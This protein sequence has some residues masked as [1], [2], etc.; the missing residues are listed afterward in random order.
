MIYYDI[1]L[2]NFHGFMSKNVGYIRSV[3]FGL[4]IARTDGISFSVQ[5]TFGADYIILI[6]YSAKRGG[7]P[8]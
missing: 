8:R 7:T 3:P 6:R 5:D 1:I 4:E 2:A